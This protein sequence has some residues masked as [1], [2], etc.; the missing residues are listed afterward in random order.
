MTRPQV[1]K[2]QQFVASLAGELMNSGALFMSFFPRNR[3][4]STLK[5]H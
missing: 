5:M 2:K 1:C 3:S 4:R